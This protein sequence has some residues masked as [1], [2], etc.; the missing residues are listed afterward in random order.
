MEAAPRIG[1]LVEVG[2]VEQ[3]E[4]VDVGREMRRHPIEHHAEAGLMGAVDEA[5]EAGRIAE[6]TRR[7]EQPDR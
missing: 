3:G 7:R 1:V 5:G 4:A 6:P 2:A